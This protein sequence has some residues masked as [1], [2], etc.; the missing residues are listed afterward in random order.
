VRVA[1]MAQKSIKAEK[2]CLYF[3]IRTALFVPPV[4]IHAK[5]NKVS[6]MPVNYFITM[7]AP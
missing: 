3:F 5:P 4:V 2:T 1:A 6:L 7:K